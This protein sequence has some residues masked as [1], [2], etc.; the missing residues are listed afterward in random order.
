MEFVKRKSNRLP[1]Y[2]YSQSG[3]Y[4]ITICVNDRMPVLSEV[5]VGANCVRPSKIGLVVENEIKIL[6]GTYK[7]VHVDK[8]VI[9]PN[10]IH[11]ILILDESIGRT[12]FAPTLSRIV[13]QFKGSITKKIGKSI[14]QRSFYDFVIRTERDYLIRWQYIDENPARWEEDKLYKEYLKKIMAQR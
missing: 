9:M 10:H 5:I 3:A 4:F 2:D 11:M 14:W 1:N 7:N 12:Q 8:Y 6:N 13:K